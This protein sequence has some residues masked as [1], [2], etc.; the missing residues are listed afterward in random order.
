MYILGNIS[1]ENFAYLV[2]TA[3]KDDVEKVKKSSKCVYKEYETKRLKC[4][5]VGLTKSLETYDAADDIPERQTESVSELV[6]NI[7]KVHACANQVLDDMSSLNGFCLI[8]QRYQ[9]LL[10]LAVTVIDM[11]ETHFPSKKKIVAEFT[12]AGPGVGVS[13]FEIRFRMVEISRLHM[14]S[15]RTRVHRASGDSAQNESERTNACTGEALVDGG[16]LQW[17]HYTPQNTHTEDE[18]NALTQEEL[19]AEQESCMKKNAWRVCEDVCERMHMEPGPAG[20]LMLCMVEGE[21]LFFYN[22]NELVRYKKTAKTKRMSLPSYNYF[23]KIENFIDSH[24]E[25]GELFLEY[26]LGSCTKDGDYDLCPF[27]KQFSNDYFCPKSPRPYPDYSHTKYKYEAME[28][29]PMEQRETD[30]FAPRVNLKTLYN[31]GSIRSENDTAVKEFSRKFIVDE[32]YVV[33]YLCHV[34]WLDVK[35]EKRQ[36]NKLTKQSAQHSQSSM[37]PVSDSSDSDD[38]ED[39]EEEVVVALI[40]TD[41]ESENDLV[42]ST[43]TTRSGRRCTTYKSR[44]FYGDTDSD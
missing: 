33:K 37:E 3:E 12:D 17:E 2:D 6:T 5:A 11:C 27:C 24:G 10:S 43:R 7:K 28:N 31:Q 36:A 15:R 35:K 44:H 39:E 42:Q 30:D 22:T 8:W 34:E 4:F 16:T 26:R 21:D 25:R 13:N 23:K 14:T 20:D 41:S 32:D 38:E 9:P 1:F 18:L 40:G 29:T 19:E